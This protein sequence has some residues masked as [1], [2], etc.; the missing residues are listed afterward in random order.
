MP[1]SPLRKY[2]PCHSHDIERTSH[3]H[4]EQIERP[5]ARTSRWTSW[6]PIPRSIRA[7]QA[8]PRRRLLFSA[9][10][11]NLC[12]CDTA[13]RGNY[14][15]F[16]SRAG[17]SLRHSWRKRAG[18]TILRRGASARFFGSQAARSDQARNGPVA[19]A[20][21][22][23]TRTRQSVLRFSSARSASLG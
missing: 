3:C 15:L 9:L 18:R 1:L 20:R 4:V 5:L 19:S 21:L 7:R 13:R 8:G 10:V 16:P 12:R 2:L 11:H 6:I 14:P 23:A 22:T 17:H